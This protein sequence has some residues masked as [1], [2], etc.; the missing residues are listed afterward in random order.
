MLL[1]TG[2]FLPIFIP[3]LSQSLYSSSNR[4]KK[5]CIGWC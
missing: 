1:F 5:N 3:S 4:S 2:S